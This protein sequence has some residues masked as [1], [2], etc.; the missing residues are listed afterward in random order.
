MR[1]DP[2]VEQAWRAALY[3]DGGFYL[4]QW[5][6]RHFA[7]A[8]HL[9]TDVARVVTRIAR[10]CGLDTVVDIGAG[11]GELVTALH[12]LEP[13]LSLVAVELRPRPAG[14]PGPVRWL[15]QVPDRLHGLVLGLELLDT[16]PCPV[17]EVDADGH[18]RVLLVDPATGCERMGAELGGHDRVWLE[19]WWPVG[20]PGMRA[21]VGRARDDAWAA[22]V[23]RLQHGVAVAVDYGHLRSTRPAS[24][25][26]RAYLRGRRVPVTYDGRVDIT[27]DV[28][29]DAVAH[30]V[31]GCVHRQR[32]LLDEQLPGPRTGPVGGGLQELAAD[33][34][35]AQVRAVG[36]LGEL[37]WVISAAQAQAPCPP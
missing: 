5:P 35:R 1:A 11:G 31:G 20:R 6:G 22:L 4:G 27:A 32:D 21:E 12:A 15:Q 14:V 13:A 33:G 25:S 3:A 10:R 37:S 34:R 17:V 8:T 23:G 19:R 28:A 26:L 16:V 30:R 9:G 18:P 2:S 36:G 24:G 7:T 29:V